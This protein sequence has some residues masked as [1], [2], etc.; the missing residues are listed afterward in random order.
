MGLP[1]DKGRGTATGMM[2]FDN[3]RLRHGGICKDIAAGLEP[4]PPVVGYFPQSSNGQCH[5]YSHIVLETTPICADANDVFT[6][7]EFEK[8][9]KAH[10]RRIGKI[11]KALK[12]CIC[13]GC[14]KRSRSQTN[15]KKLGWK[16]RPSPCVQYA[17]TVECFCPKCFEL[18]GWGDE[19]FNSVNA[20]ATKGK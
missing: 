16:T 1:K 6:E 7:E 17:N 20:Q 9:I 5:P 11:R 3:I 15:P 2:N 12:P 8:K 4:L 18:Y 10:M 13:W 14:G 19:L